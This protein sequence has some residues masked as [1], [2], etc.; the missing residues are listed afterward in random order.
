[1]FYQEDSILSYEQILNNSVLQISRE[2]E[3]TLHIALSSRDADKSIN[4]ITSLLRVVT[5]AKYP[6]EQI[7]SY[8][9]ELLSI[10]ISVSRENNF[11]VKHLFQNY[12][13]KINDISLFQSFSDCKNSFVDF[14]NDF[15]NYLYS[16]APH[17]RYEIVK[18]KEYVQLHYMENIDL[19]LISELVNITPSH[20][21]N[22]FKKETG[23]NF[24]TYLTRIRMNEAHRL[25]LQPDTLIYEVAEKTGYANSSYFGKAF[26][27]YYGMSP[28]EFKVQNLNRPS[29]NSDMSPYKT[30]SQ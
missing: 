16:L 4:E 30:N 10:Y 9:D 19:N 1:M 22:L 13:D 6:L 15:I 2:N 25:L 20:L 18:I 27:K 3:K 12:L 11:S 29:E 26:R 28:E 24:T 17:E 7:Q 23:E 5:N 21:S 14:T 8:L